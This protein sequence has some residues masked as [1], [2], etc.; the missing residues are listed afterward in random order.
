MK[1]ALPTENKDINS[2]LCASFGRAP[3]YLIYDTSAQSSVFVDNTAAASAGGAGIKAAQILVDS[4]IDALI[5]PRCGQNAALV[6]QAANIALYQSKDAT[7]AQNI[8]LLQQGKLEKL[9][10]IHAGLHNH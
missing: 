6:L 1:I 10:N 8:A 2:M 9:S 7:L 3:Y 5:T 4:G